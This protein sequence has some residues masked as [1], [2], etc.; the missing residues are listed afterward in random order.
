[1]LRETEHPAITM[2]IVCSAVHDRVF[3]EYWI[4]RFRERRRWDAK[5]STAI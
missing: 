5:S 2:R 1:M 4:V 3:G